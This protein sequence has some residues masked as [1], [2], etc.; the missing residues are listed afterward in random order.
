V[1]D[2]QAVCQL[3]LNMVGKQKVVCSPYLA[4]PS[5]T[6]ENWQGVVNLLS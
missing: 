4:L 5:H 3:N 6:S 1:V 2:Y